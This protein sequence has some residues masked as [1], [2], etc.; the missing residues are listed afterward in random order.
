MF[1]FATQRSPES[2]TFNHEAFPCSVIHYS[3]L[4]KRKE[5]QERTIIVPV[6]RDASGISESD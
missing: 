2:I 6:I 3:A 5:F 4:F 1:W